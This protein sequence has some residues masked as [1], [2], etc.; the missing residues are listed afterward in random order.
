MPDRSGLGHKRGLAKFKKAYMHELSGGT[1][2]RAALTRPA[3]A[4]NGRAVRLARRHDARATL[5]RNAPSADA[6]QVAKQIKQNQAHLI[7]GN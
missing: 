5:F 2:Q 6:L 4:P 3:C 1:K 7:W